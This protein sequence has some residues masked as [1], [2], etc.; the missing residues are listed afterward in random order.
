MRRKQLSLVMHESMITRFRINSLS[1]LLSF[2]L[3]YSYPDSHFKYKA[4][5]TLSLGGMRTFLANNIKVYCTTRGLRVRT[6]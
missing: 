1:T 6:K 5:R 2:D 3:A 4:N